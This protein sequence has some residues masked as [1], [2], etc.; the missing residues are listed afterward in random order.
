MSFGCS[1]AISLK[2]K[3]K[4]SSGIS[5]MSLDLQ[6]WLERHFE[7][8]DLLKVVQN[9]QVKKSAECISNF[10][11]FTWNIDKFMNCGNECTNLDI[12]NTRHVWIE[13]RHVN[14][15]ARGVKQFECVATAISI[16]K[17]VNFCSRT[18]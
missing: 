1:L 3:E 11:C 13:T 8:G 18:S 6:C 12:L 16:S 7:G 15:F 2:V 10:V 17:R 5:L 4:E 14:N 9:N